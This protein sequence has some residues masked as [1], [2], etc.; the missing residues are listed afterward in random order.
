[1]GRP[2]IL[3]AS[4]R[5]DLPGF[6]GQACAERIRQRRARLRTRQLWAVM[7]WTRHTKSF[8]PS[9]PLHRLVADELSNPFVQLTITGLGGTRIEPKTPD[10]DVILASLPELVKTFHGEP[11]RI[12]WRFDPLLKGFTSL[13]TFRR[14]GEKMSELEIKSCTFSYPSYFSLK[15]DLKPHFE[16]AGIPP[17][18]EREQYEF[19]EELSHIARD[20]GLQLQVCAQPRI[21][22]LHPDIQE[23]QCIPKELIERGHSPFEPLSLPKDRSQRTHCLCIESEDIGD[24]I[25][26]PCHGG[27]VYCYSKAGGP[28]KTPGTQ[29][30]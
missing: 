7:F 24:Y 16:R 29:F 27:C 3:S 9:G 15:G 12:L 21:A 17:W 23:A 5:T 8:L 22:A 20:L 4:R 1:M 25:Q 28:P 13:T 6:H 10:T 30:S 2:L 19:T 11:W 18:T 26:D 14:I